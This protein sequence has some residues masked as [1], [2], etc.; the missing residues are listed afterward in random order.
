MSRNAR[1][2]W[3]VA[4]ATMMAICVFAIWQSLLLSLTDRLGPGPG[5]FSFWLSLLGVLFAGLLIFDVWRKP[6]IESG[7]TL[8][9][10]GESAFRVLIIIGTVAG[11]TLL[12]GWVGFE[13]A[14]LAFIAG[15]TFALGERRWYA[16]GL[17][18]IAGSFGVYYVFTRW[19]DVLLPPGPWAA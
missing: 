4:T 13:L 12:M 16:I 14:M 1:R 8:F 11:A 9:P 2:G 7:E 19:L 17:F 18:A 3:L 5:F 6:V 10:R 15:L